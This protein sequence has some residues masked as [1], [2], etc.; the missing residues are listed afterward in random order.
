MR[1]DRVGGGC[2]SLGKAPA[3][4]PYSACEMSIL[5]EDKTIVGSDGKDLE[6]DKE[7]HILINKVS[8]VRTACSARSNIQIHP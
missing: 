3:L 4:T 5:G 1:S 8:M 7:S 6:S 2:K